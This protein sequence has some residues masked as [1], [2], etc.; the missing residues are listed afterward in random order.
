MVKVESTTKQIQDCLELVL[1][2]LCNELPK[3][4]AQLWWLSSEMHEFLILRGVN[5]KLK[6]TDLTSLLKTLTKRLALHSRKLHKQR[7]YQ[8]KGYE[9]CTVPRNNQPS[10]KKI[11][12]ECNFLHDNES[13]LTVQK[14]NDNTVKTS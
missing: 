13:F 3:E 9:I 7:Y 12:T 14:L 4:M 5:D 11:A 1:R 10:L 8:M 2:V 6:M